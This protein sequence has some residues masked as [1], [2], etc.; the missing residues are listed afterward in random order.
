MEKDKDRYITVQ[1]VAEIL[2][3]TEKHIY[4]LIQEGSLQSI[5]IGNRAVRISEKSLRD[6]IEKNKVNPDD[7]FD[8]EREENKDIRANQSVVK[9]KWMQK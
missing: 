3:C 2:S 6:F 9:S 5:K 4:F 7:F 1:F 8:P